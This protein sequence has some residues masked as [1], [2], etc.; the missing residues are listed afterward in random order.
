MSSNGYSYGGHHP[1]HNPNSPL[2]GSQ[3]SYSMPPLQP[4]VPLLSTGPLGGPSTSNH[5]P[6]MS[7]GLPS[8]H[9]AHPPSNQSHHPLTFYNDPYASPYTP[10]AQ[11]QHHYTPQYVPRPIS[12]ASN[13]HS[14]APT[15]T[16]SS[17]ISTHGQQTPAG[18]PIADSSSVAGRLPSGTESPPPPPSVTKA[19]SSVACA[20]CRKQK[21]SR[22]RNLRQTIG[23]LSSLT[24]SS[25]FDE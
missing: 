2:L 12:A 25:S 21:A 16:N 1:S 4:G 20:L 17:V 3:S 8:M 24:L 19:R 11:Q 18:L 13:H 6:G 7:H 15:A 5:A 14:P 10:V 22:F 9:Q 23:V